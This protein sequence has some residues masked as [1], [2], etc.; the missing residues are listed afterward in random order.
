[1]IA[2]LTQ[3][4]SVTIAISHQD[5]K[6]RKLKV[7]ARLNYSSVERK[8]KPKQRKADGTNERGTLSFRCQPHSTVILLPFT[9]KSKQIQKPV[10]VFNLLMSMSKNTQHPVMLRNT[11][12][13]LPGLTLADRHTSSL[14]VTPRVST[15]KM[16]IAR[17]TREQLVPT[18]ASFEAPMTLCFNH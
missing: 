9:T 14:P 6:K 15:L 12:I 18:S 2:G 16:V 5:H 4:P 10:R 3:I 1:M 17:E 7:S 8:P 11:L 13:L